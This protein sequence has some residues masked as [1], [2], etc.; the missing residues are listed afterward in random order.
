MKKVFAVVVVA[1]AASIPSTTARSAFPGGNGR[2]AFTSEQSGSYE[3][4]VMNA[5]GS[6][7]T[8]LAARAMEPAWSPDG[9]KIA[10]ATDRNG[11]F[12]IYVM[13]ADGSGQARLTKNNGVDTWPAWSP[14]GSK[15]VFQALRNGRTSQIYVMNADGSA[16]TPL[17][18]GT[19]SDENPAWSPDGRAIA[20]SSLRNLTNRI[21]VMNADGSGETA[22]T[23]PRFA[24]LPKWSPDGRKIAYTDYTEFADVFEMNADGS[25][26]TRIT[27]SPAKAAHADWSPDGTRFVFSTYRDGINQIYVMNADGSA[28]TRLTNDLRNDT[29]PAWQ[30]IPSADLSLDLGARASART[31]MVTYSIR[32]ADA[33]PSPAA[34]VVVNDTIPAQSTAVAARPSQG[35]C[36]TSSNTARPRTVVCSL[37][38]LSAGA[39]ASVQVD[40]RF[41]RRPLPR[42]LRITDT[43]DVTSSTPDQNLPNN[44][45][46]VAATIRLTR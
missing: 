21:Y 9:S 41:A 2:I 22:L 36:K 5:D 25:N 7:R 31:R 46:S 38:F 45:A 28:Q 15:I 18:D 24:Y 11:S 30:P 39:A 10:F 32:V 43:A 12:Q 29:Y 34:A 44:T 1:V 3:I 20:Y 6:G 23:G 37:G 40:V 27:P 14:D 33:G 16:Q 8:M 42:T 17:T 19:Y 35:R 13:N 4:D 26:Q